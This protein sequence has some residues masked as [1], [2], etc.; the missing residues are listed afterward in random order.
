MSLEDTVEVTRSA[1]AIA[2][3][4]CPWVSINNMLIRNCCW[5]C[6]QPFPRGTTKK[7]FQV[8]NVL[9]YF[10]ERYRVEQMMPA[11]MGGTSAA[12]S[13]ENESNLIDTPS[14]FKSLATF[15]SKNLA[16]CY[17]H[18]KRFKQQSSS[19]DALLEQLREN[20]IEVW[21]SGLVCGLQQSCKE[22]VA[23]FVKPIGSNSDNSTATVK[24]NG[25]SGKAV[26]PAGLT[27]FNKKDCPPGCGC[28]NP[29]AFIS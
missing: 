17:D 18:Y 2:E 10:E 13:L 24:S 7:A 14:V 15:K 19:L 28:D 26:T 22:D 16:S 21:M 4:N 25:S 29:W 27:F 9:T 1:A 6:E 20:D 5:L 12:S 8:D 23:L 3:A 11:T